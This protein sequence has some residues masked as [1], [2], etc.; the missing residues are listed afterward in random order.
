M[1]SNHFLVGFES[2]VLYVR[3][4]E[5]IAERLKT[6]APPELSEPAITSIRLLSMLIELGLIGKLYIVLIRWVERTSAGCYALGV[7]C[8]LEERIAKAKGNRASTLRC[9]S[10]STSSIFGRSNPETC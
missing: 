8:S 7:E 9:T 4:E 1:S 3:Y 6:D 5:Q 10:T 2:P